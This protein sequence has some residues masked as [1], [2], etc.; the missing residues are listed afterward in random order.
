MRPIYLLPGEASINDVAS[1]VS[2]PAVGVYI[3][4]QLYLQGKYTI[5]EAV[6]VM[7]NFSVCSL[8]FFGLLVSIVGKVELYPYVV[9]SSFIIVFIMGAIVVR[10]WPLSKR[11]NVYVDGRKLTVED[12]QKEKERSKGNIIARAFNRGI[13]AAGQFNPKKDIILGLFDALK[14]AQKI[15]AYVIAFATIALFLAEYTPLFIWLGKP[16]IPYLKILGMP[17][18]EEIAPSTLIG[19][20]EIALPPALIAGKDIALKSI[21]FI[22]VLTSVQIIFFSESAQAM[23]QCHLRFTVLELVIIFLERTIIA[24]PIIALFAHILFK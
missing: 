22:I 1:F 10:I 24:M 16:M 3:T 7:T 14:F 11:P 15:V 4:D 19:I 5:R 8:G 21:Y 12:I 18:A 20:A 2:A 23:L 17:N 6:T 13:M 9:I